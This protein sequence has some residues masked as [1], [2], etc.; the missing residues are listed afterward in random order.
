MPNRN[1]PAT[2][3]S[4]TRGAPLFVA[5]A[6]AHAAAIALGVTLL[7]SGIFCCPM[8]AI[9][10]IPCPACGSTRAARAL[11]ALDVPGAFRAHPIAPFVV[12]LGALLSARWVLSVARNGTSRHFGAART[13]R[14]VLQVLVLAVALEIVTWILRFFGMLGG[15][16]PV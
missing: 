14:V 13:D 1:D 4:Y 11:L 5:R 10:H 2:K 15:P 16:S 3:P 7:A 9:F 6:A 8:A 12:L